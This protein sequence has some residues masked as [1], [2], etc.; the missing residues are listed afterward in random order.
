MVVMFFVLKSLPISF[1]YLENSCAKQCAT[2]SE[3]SREFL[4]SFL[5]GLEFERR[6]E[7]WV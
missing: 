7:G 1:K 3:D 6:P 2:N 5:E 4:Q